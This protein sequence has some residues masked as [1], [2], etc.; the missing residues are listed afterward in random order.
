MN[1]KNTAVITS[2]T[3]FANVSTTV[4]E[5]SGEQCSVDI[6]I[7]TFNSRF[8][9][10]TCKLPSALSGYEMELTQRLKAGLIR[11][12]VYC[13]VR[14]NSH[15]ALLEK[16]V[17]SPVRVSEYLAA[18]DIMKQTFGLSGDVSI[19]ELM[20]LPQVFA[21]ERT[22][23]SD[24]A[25]V[26]FLSGVDEAIAQVLVARGHEG[27]TLLVDLS[28]RL[29]NIVQIMGHIEVVITRLLA[30]QKEEVAHCQQLAQ[31]GDEA[32]RALL[33]ERLGALDKMDVH[34]EIVR[35]GSHVGAIER[36]L[37]DNCVEKGRKLDFTLQELMREIN[38]ITAKCTNYEMSSHAVN[39]KVE[40]E[41]IREQ[42]QNIV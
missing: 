16:M 20:S 42:V 25:I 15:G 26:R 36:L 24:D 23:L 27:R 39:I 30:A 38:T 4:L 40:I 41:K 11:G 21:T 18:R 6:E 5:Y 14:I 34:E 10:P 17:F 19:A 29:T 22:Q 3:G 13:T 35:F 32:A 9:E 31:N 2:M 1:I 7:K 28:Q 37:A 12:R 33:P 8:F